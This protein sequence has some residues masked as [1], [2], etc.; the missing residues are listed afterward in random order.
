MKLAKAGQI[1]K[2]AYGL[3]TLAL[4]PILFYRT[5]WRVLKARRHKRELIRS[6]PLLVLF[7]TAWAFGEA[8]GYWRG[9]GN[10]LAK[11]R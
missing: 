6:L 11:V 7:V 10:T 9:P 5:V 4:P 8:V 1:Q 2:F 3:S